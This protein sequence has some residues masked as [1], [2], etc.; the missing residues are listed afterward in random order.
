MNTNLQGLLALLFILS[1]LSSTH[2][3]DEKK[4]FT[5]KNVIRSRE[6]SP[7]YVY[8][9]RS[10]SDGESYC[11]LERDSLNIYSYRTGER[12]GTIVTSDQLIPAGDTIP[13]PMFDFEFSADENK[14][15]FATE[16]ESIYR[17]SSES[18]YYIF[19]RADGTL[20]RLSEKGKQRLADFSPDGSK[21]AFVRKNNL[22]VKDIV[23][24]HEAQLTFDGE[25][26]KIIYGTTDWVY[27]EEFG[28]TKAFFWSHDGA[29][30]AFYRFD[31]SAVR[32]FQMTTWGDLYPENY[33]YKYPKAGED[34]SVVEIFVYHLD[35][36]KTI[37]MET[38]EEQDIY[39]PRINWTHIPGKL[40]IQWMN[41][42][43]NEL[44]I[45]LADASTGQSERI[46]HE[47]NK[48]YIDITDNLT[49]LKDN[50]SF[51]LTSEQDGY[52][53][54]YLYNMD[55]TLA[56]QITGGEWDV[57]EF[58]GVDEDKG[59]VYFTSAET[60][61]LNRELYVIKTDGTK[62]KKLSEKDGS[63]NIRFAEKFKYYVNTFSDAKTPP[64]ITIHT[65]DGKLVRVLKDNSALLDKLA[66]YN[67]S[68][69]EF[70][71]FT[72]SEGVE[73]NGWMIRPADFDPQRKYPVL[74]YVYG[75]PGSQTVRNSW[76]GG[77]LWYQ[78]LATK[79]M[80]IVSVDNRGTGARGEEFKKMTYLQLGKYEIIDQIEAAKYLG[81]LS[82]VDAGKIGIWGWSYGGYMSALGI[83]KGADVFSAAIAVAPVTN[84]RYYDN[85]YTER[86]M[87]TPQENPDGYDD[88]SPINHVE[89]MK[90]KFLIIHGTADD[91]VHVQNSVDLISA[92]VDADKQFE[93]QLYPNSNHGIYTGMNTTMHLYTR[94]TQFILDNLLNN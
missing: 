76:G 38:G 33:K 37:K 15:L 83:T 73:L 30:I 88:N 13:V 46:Y 19:D 9:M 48:Y 84:W 47:A 17:Y 51:I 44:V 52:N 69:K 93:M 20:N 1:S 53:H 66:D 39:I 94:L 34:N 68:P 92:L 2:A 81:S 54:L 25:F 64:Y 14:I 31:E 45:L 86:F 41:R 82:Y 78:M 49:F 61:P 77:D 23:R 4:E 27:E 56:N 42:V 36:G 72:T 58:I 3:Q 67:F 74:M 57:T 79:G 85:I 35:S 62:K 70:F 11:L 24:D 43:Q 16:T 29:Q 59:L 60:S 55:G 75:G 87:R 91:N 90:G 8:G 18:E 40:A 32:E 89:K 21:V 65:S 5:L 10:L 6:F 63:N 22:F 71:T 12:T 80:I 26:N 50:Q 7:S 28:I